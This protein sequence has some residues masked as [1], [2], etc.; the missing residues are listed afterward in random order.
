M[1]AVVAPASVPQ[2]AEDRR[3]RPAGPSAGSPVL[4]SGPQG[5][6]FGLAQGTDRSGLP[7]LPAPGCTCLHVTC[8]SSVVF[9]HC[10]TP[11]AH[12]ADAFRIPRRIKTCDMKK[13]R[14]QMYILLC[15][16][17]NN[18]ALINRSERIISVAH[19]ITLVHNTDV[20]NCYLF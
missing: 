13:R 16:W 18:I 4:A 1:A 19:K 5:G 15:S 8:T 9:F 3:E 7:M 10:T 17:H 20:E 12:A 14:K 2:Q 11:K 6:A